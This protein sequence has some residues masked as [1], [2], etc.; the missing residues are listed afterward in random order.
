MHPI[1]DQWQGHACKSLFCLL[2]LWIWLSLF[3]A[4]TP[5]FAQPHPGDLISPVNSPAACITVS[6]ALDTLPALQTE[7][8]RS[9]PEQYWQVDDTG[10]WQSGANTNYCL[11]RKSSGSWTLTVR[12]CTDPLTLYLQ[13]DPTHPAI[14]TV[15]GD[16]TVLDNYGSEVGLWSKHGGAN[17]QWRWFQQD[18][19]FIAQHANV[20]VTYP[21]SVNDPQAIFKYNLE[22]AR[23]R[24]ARMQ[25]PFVVPAAAYRDAAIYPGA[26]GAGAVRASKTVT[27]HLNFRDHGYLRMAAP[28][29]NWQST[30]LY[31]P[32]NTVIT[33]TVTGATQ[34]E[35]QNVSVQLGQQTDFLSM[36][37]TNVVG[38]GALKRFPSIAMNVKLVPGV[39]Q[40]RTPY[41]GPVILRSDASIDKT[42]TV[43]VENAVLE[44]YFKLGET[45]ETQWLAV[46]NSPTPFGEIES[47]YFVA[48]APSSE[49][50]QRTYDEMVQI[51]QHYDDVARATNDLSGLSP[52]APLPHTSPMGKHRIAEDIQISAGYG[53]SGFPIQ[54]Y[55][56]WGVASPEMYTRGANWGTWHELGHNYQMGAWSYVY[57][58]ETTVNLWSLYIQEKLFRV[59]RLINDDRFTHAAAML[60]DPAVTDKWNTGSPWHM[61]VFLD[62]I[63]LAFPTHNWNLWTQLMRRYREMSSAE[64]NALDTDA[65]R[66]DKVLEIL[67]DLTNTNL[68]PHFNVWTVP[69]SQSAKNF[70]ASKPALSIQP[71]TLDGSQPIYHIGNGTGAFRREWWS[72]LT[73]TALTDLTNTPS[74]PSQ[75]S[76]TE[77]LTGTLQGPRNWNDQYGQR[78]RGYLHPPV[79]G[80][81][82]FWISGDDSA[83][84]WL[85]SDT[86]PLNA[87]PVLTLTQATGDQDFDALSVK[88]QRSQ[89]IALEAGRSYYFHVLHKEGSGSDHL[90]VAWSIPASG[91]KPLE[92][93]K[94]IA[95]RYLSPY[96]GNLALQKTLAAGQS[97]TVLRGSDITFTLTTFNQSSST[98]RNIEILDTLPTGFT[99]SPLNPPGRWQTGY[100]YVR[101]E[102]LSE[103]GNRGP[104]TT[105][106]ELGLLNGDGQPIPKNGWRVQYV[107]SE[108]PGEGASRAFDG[109][110]ATFWH[111]RWQGSQP[112]HPHELQIDLGNYYPR[113]SGFTYLPRQS[114]SNGRIGQYRFYVS[115]TGSQWIQVAEG[116]FPDTAALQTVSIS[117]PPANEVFGLLPGPVAPGSSASLELVARTAPE[118]ALGTYTNTA[119]VRRALDGINSPLYDRN[120]ADN[121]GAV[122]VQVALTVPPT[123][124]T[125]ETPTP[126]QTP[127]TPTPTQ[128]P[129]TPTP[130]QTPET[131]TP[132]QT[133]ETPTPTQTPETPTPTPSL[134]LT[135]IEPNQGLNTIPNEVILQGTGLRNDSLF[136]IGDTQLEI[137]PAAIPP[138][139]KMTA[140]VPAGLAPGLYDVVVRNPDGTEYTL[141]D[142]YTVID[143][144]GLDLAVT[145]SDFWSDPATPRQGTEM[146][147]GIN[148]HRS[149]GS[150][151]L[152]PVTV[153]F[154]LDTVDPGSLLGTSS[155]PPLGPGTDVVDSAFIV[156]TPAETGQHTLY[157]VVD[158]AGQVGE[159]SE[160]NNS[161]QWR[162]DVQPAV[163]ADTTPPSLNTLQIAD[164][165]Q[166]TTQPL[167]QLAFNA[168]DNSGT[169]ATMYLVERV[170]SNA[171]RRWIPLQQSGWIPYADTF[172]STLSAGGGVHYLQLWA[173]DP[174]GNVSPNSLQ[175]PINYL[176]E[177]DRVRTGQVRLY[178]L[179]LA[180]GETLNATVTPS[181]G[182]PDL[183][184]WDSSGALVDY[185]NEYDQTADQVTFTAST[186]GTY[187]IEVYG[188]ADSLYGISLSPNL[189]AQLTIA[190]SPN[191]K[192]VPE[193]PSVAAD[194]APPGQQALPAAPT[195]GWQLFLPLTTR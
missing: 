139:T 154:Y 82:E 83:Q 16:N 108:N 150:Q 14:Y 121:L 74:Y 78:L 45:T 174:A 152:D 4:A 127:E 146:T 93:R 158:S 180:A 141:P 40:V 1:K 166:S 57:G 71:W 161:A 129:E 98:A 131:P 100:R 67:C 144:D 72:S 54:A 181:T 48:H 153:H 50:A 120:P 63:R 164:G 89:P 59:S 188:Y 143:A 95:P 86:D 68:S 33:L 25:P 88:I 191:A 96:T 140:L 167:A 126:T 11:A 53:H 60:N 2:S 34:N 169:V 3:G 137:V 10:R 116:T 46:R 9:K 32:P 81:Y 85:S 22:L 193:T 91:S 20:A 125:P 18:L 117:T 182:D 171:A 123:T 38:D 61:L 51:A 76:G 8:C 41:G 27:F 111:T 19:D 49:L 6:G 42:L 157:A 28:P 80:N 145:D 112:P 170:Y 115:S 183:Y 66:L 178:R 194:A 37:S 26:V 113:L 106:A 24:V 39:N 133:P 185:S 124:P 168:T 43:T 69:V 189:S 5:T 165:S 179:T 160:T 97:A 122:A 75:P 135:Q 114:G 149:G 7:V 107:D 147:I 64:I 176:P 36:S 23:D 31:A 29:H 118:L 70:C 102:A 192:T 44:P 58:V 15:V 73:G 21:I 56:G 99:L 128:T 119:T 175:A 172:S 79:T 142:S 186:A 159:G 35:L 195:T 103:A 94:L 90:A 101:I 30:G 190:S 47:H 105:I 52:D 184:L 109:D 187:Q 92:I 17:Q 130:T 148:V 62:Q 138:T 173:A 13:P 162:F 132:T 136:T 87:A 65:K 77:L 163:T 84:L 104:W 177:E 12:P 110:P 134:Q 55:T 155:V 151:T 156:W